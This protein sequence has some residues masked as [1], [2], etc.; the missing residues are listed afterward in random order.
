[1]K[2]LLI[3]SD[4]FSPRV[5][6]IARF[7]TDL[8]PRLTED[9]DITVIAPDYNGSTD[10]KGTKIVKVPVYR[11]QLGDYSPPKRDIKEMRKHIM[12]A[13]LVWSQTI[14]PLGSAAITIARREGKRTVAFIHSL[15]WELFSRGVAKTGIFRKPIETVTRSFA[16]NKYNQC[17]LL[18][19]PSRRAMEMLQSIGITTD[20]IIVH[21]GIETDRFKPPRSKRK[22]KEKIG[23]EPDSEVIG[24]IGRIAKEKDLLTL[25]KAFERIRDERRYLLVVGSGNKSVESKLKGKNVIRTGSVKDPL[26]YYQALDVFVLSSLTETTS[27]STME[28]MASEVPVVCTPVGLIEEYVEDTKNGFIFRKGSQKQLADTIQMLLE[29]GKLRRRI[30]KEGRKTI[31]VRY[32]WSKTVMKLISILKH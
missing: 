26:P 21:L 32:K 31:N 2:K 6:G 27:L 25:L 3:V 1:M 18:I 17:D 11:I 20:M 13:D 5:D 23:L 8:L 7:L 22:A 29:D 24:Y 30:G 14:G 28:A 10:V 4:T 19:V 15:E 12:E 9:F 16:K